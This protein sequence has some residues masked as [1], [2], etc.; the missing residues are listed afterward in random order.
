[1]EPIWEGK[2]FRASHKCPE[3]AGNSLAALFFTFI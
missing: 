1:M 2:C 3:T